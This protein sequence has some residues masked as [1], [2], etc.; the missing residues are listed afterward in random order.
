MTNGSHETMKN[1]PV[2]LIHFYVL[3]ESPNKPLLR[4]LRVNLLLGKKLND[5][6]GKE[7]IELPRMVEKILHSCHS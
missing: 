5:Y 1:I 6:R 7:V 2:W 3:F 4:A